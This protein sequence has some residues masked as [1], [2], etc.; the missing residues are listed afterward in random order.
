MN[1]I[2]R[3]F[4]LPYI[5]PAQAQ[6]HVP[7]NQA[8]ND[9]DILIH[10]SAIDDT[11]STPPTSAIEGDCH[12][13]GADAVGDWAGR[14]GE[15]ALMQDGIWRFIR[16]QTGL[17]VW[18]QATQTLKVYHAGDWQTVVSDTGSGTG[19]GTGADGLSAYDL[20]VSQGY[21]GSLSEWLASLVGPT[22]ATGPAGPKGPTGPAGADGRDGTNGVDGTNGADGRD[23]TNGSDGASAYDIWISQGNTGTEADFLESLSVST[24]DTSK[25]AYKAATDLNEALPAFPVTDGISLAF[26]PSLKI[27][28]IDFSDPTAPKIL[29]LRDSATGIE[30]TSY[31]TEPPLLKY[32][33]KN[34]LYYMYTDGASMGLGLDDFPI[35]KIV[36]ADGEAASVV[37]IST[38][39]VSNQSNF[40][41]TTKLGPNEYSNTRRMGVHFPWGNGNFYWDFGS[42][43][44]GRVNTGSQKHLAD[45]STIRT[46]ALTA[47]STTQKITVDGQTLAEA[48]PASSFGSE[49]VV[50]DEV[51]SLGFGYKTAT[52]GNPADFAKMN[53]FAFIIY[54][55]A[56]T[57]EEIS[58]INLWK[59]NVIGETL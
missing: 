42:T 49:G 45:N 17:L 48:N 5:M 46:I 21:T 29:A 54:N 39:N 3:R 43:S 19:T 9:L 31:P 2:T 8:L 32:S 4:A 56:L 15:I 58:K 25:F 22:S 50:S 40:G 52:A 41:Y 11:H 24:S 18:V 36:S 38:L 57:D 27:S 7:H 55:R 44:N 53:C 20:A 23:G 47:S 13:I 51:G 30:M 1:E 14:D 6:K 28:T 33:S 12:I 37:C 26:I 16:P 34:N 35:S 10:A 59:K